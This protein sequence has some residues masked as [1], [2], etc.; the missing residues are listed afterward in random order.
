LRESGS[1]VEFELSDSQEFNKNNR[2]NY[3]SL[4]YN[5]SYIEDVIEEEN[6]NENS[7]EIYYNYE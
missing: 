5:K 1:L 4:K 3:K 2:N 7:Q 6:E